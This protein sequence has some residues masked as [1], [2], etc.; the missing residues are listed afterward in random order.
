MTRPSL[1]VLFVCLL[2][3]S[4][5]DGERTA[6]AQEKRA[7]NDD[8]RLYR[9]TPAEGSALLKSWNEY[10]KA[11]VISDAAWAKYQTLREQAARRAHGSAVWCA[12]PNVDF[13]FLV[14]TPGCGEE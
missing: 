4:G 14:Q 9:L 6:N 1:A 2:L 11:K 5:H 3:W 12:Q 13:T 8:Y 7:Q 10:A